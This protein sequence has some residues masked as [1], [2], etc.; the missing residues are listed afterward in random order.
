MVVATARSGV[1]LAGALIVA[2]AV[3]S[4]SF[5]GESEETLIEQELHRVA[6]RAKPLRVNPSEPLRS[7]TCHSTR[8]R[9]DEHTLYLCTVTF[10]DTVI[11]DIC[12]IVRGGTVLMGG[13]EFGAHRCG[14]GT[15]FYPPRPDKFS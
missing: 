2:V 4:C 7:V 9:V 14:T 12:A 1:R 15:R 13:Q 11:P 6:T 8:T 5:G 3:A 10:R